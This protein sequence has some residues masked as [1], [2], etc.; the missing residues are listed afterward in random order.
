MVLVLDYL[1]VVGEFE[2]ARG[3]FRFLVKGQFFDGVYPDEGSE[4]LNHLAHLILTIIQQLC[5]PHPRLLQHN[6]SVHRG[7]VRRKQRTPRALQSLVLLRLDI[8]YIPS[9]HIR[10]IRVQV[11]RVAGP[12]RPGRI[13]ALDL[14]RE[15]GLVDE[16]EEERD[17]LFVALLYLLPLQLVHLEHL[18]RLAVHRGRQEVDEHVQN[19]AFPL[20]L[21]LLERGEVNGLEGL[22]ED[23]DVELVS[24]VKGRTRRGRT[25]SGRAA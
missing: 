2:G 23:R 7:R 13:V 3:A 5:R 15:Q 8:H 9:A 21:L 17:L 20:L 11:G 24:G 16:G 18:L 10:V 22:L 6:S 12:L 1:E 4:L 19:L 14:G 25:A